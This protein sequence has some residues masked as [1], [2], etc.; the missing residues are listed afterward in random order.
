MAPWLGER[1]GFALMP[2]T[3]SQ[4]HPFAIA[5]QARDEE[6]ARRGVA[7]LQDCAAKGQQRA[8]S[9]TVGV[10]FGNGYLL[11]SQ[12]QADADAYAR[13]AAQHSLADDPDFTADMGSLGDPGVA[14]M[15][16]DVPAAVSAFGGAGMAPGGV[17][18]FTSTAQRVA[19]TVR[20]GSDH[21]EIAT[22]VF[23]DA[24]SVAH[25]DNPVVRLP[26]STV[27]AVS[28]SGADQRLAQLWTGS[29]AKA[30]AHDLDLDRQISDFENRTGLSLPGDLETILGHNIMVVIDKEGLTS[31]RLAGADPS[32]LDFGM[33]F[34]NDPAKLDALY[35]K[36]L[37]LVRSE[38]DQSMPF[39]KLDA[40]DG[41]VVASN[42]GYAKK[43]GALDGTLGDSD[44]FRSVVDDGAGKEFVLF[45]N[46]EA[47]RDQ[48]M[49]SMRAQ[50]MSATVTENLQPLKAFGI[51]EDVDGDYLHATCRLSVGD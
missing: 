34:T 31:D 2:P 7:V 51:T 47:V 41:M 24:S 15:W 23:G 43:L 5:L 13:E 25:D 17:S 21:V 14:T 20:F 45:V 11:L 49:R 4:P 38:A 46:L 9:T 28:E 22:S 3:S 29:V 36:M 8:L 30:R 35:D 48:V 37:G 6:A 1:F 42:D 19:A 50:G 40:P 12:T 26:D 16:V 39:V 33:R 10:A 32:G 44:A 27:F 18:D